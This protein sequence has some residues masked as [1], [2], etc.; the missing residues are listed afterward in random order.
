MIKDDDIEHCIQ[1]KMVKEK[2]FQTATKVELK[3][4]H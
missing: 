1:G 4:K 2:V 3:L